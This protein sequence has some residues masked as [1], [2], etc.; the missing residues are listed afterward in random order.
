M[1][2]LQALSSIHLNVIQEE[3]ED[4]SGILTTARRPRFTKHLG[5]HTPS[6]TRNRSNSMKELERNE[7]FRDKS[8]RSS[9]S[10]GSRRSSGSVSSRR[11]SDT[12]SSTASFKVL[13]PINKN[14]DEDDDEEDGN[15]TNDDSDP[16][17]TI[18]GNNA[19]EVKIDPPGDELEEPKE[20][21]KKRKNSL[22]CLGSIVTDEGLVQNIVEGF[23]LHKVSQQQV[24]RMV[25]MMIQKDKDDDSILSGDEVRTCLSLSGVKISSGNITRLLRVAMKGNRRYSIETI[26]GVI[27][28][29]IYAAQAEG[30]AIGTSDKSD[31][32]W[33]VLL[34]MFTNL[35]KLSES[36]TEESLAGRR[37]KCLTQLRGALTS[38][39]NYRDGFMSA[40]DV[41]QQTLAHCTVLA[42]GLETANLRQAINIARSHSLHRG[43]VN[44]NIFLDNL[45][46]TAKLPSK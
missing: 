11:S 44:V 16:E 40:S 42:V 33:K 12:I 6:P 20:L 43:L 3:S 31:T 32:D 30:D 36:D 2:T 22:P 10:F 17:I 28:R 37:E 35:P 41:V 27:Q 39:Q 23:K 7:E 25:K 21:N 24:D 5:G 13:P 1:K 14:E 45:M 34:E 18:E 8:R 9:D 26:A 29:G 4:P 46:P 15:K 38:H 19:I